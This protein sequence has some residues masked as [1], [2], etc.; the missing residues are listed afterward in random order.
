MSTTTKRNPKG[1]T[2]RIKDI[3]ATIGTLSKT[4]K[5]PSLSFS[6]PAS[7]CI[8][9]QKLAKNALSVCAGCYAG[10]GSY[11]WRTTKLAQQKRFDALTLPNWKNLMQELIS[12]RV[13]N[14]YFRWF[15]SGDIQSLAMLKDIVDICNNLSHIKFW[16]PTKEYGIV[17]KYIEEGGIIPNNL[18]I[19]ISYPFVEG[20]FVS[21]VMETKYKGCTQ[22]TVSKN[23]NNVSCLSFTQKGKCLD[24]R[25]CWDKNEGNITYRLH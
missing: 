8:T 7:K 10:K 15:D 21:S 16:L 23:M 5:M 24:C 18:N 12:L 11:V 20:E 13:K 17:S 19:R 22:S 4:S 2:Q 1:S 9:G 25:K 14:N 6:I 3:C